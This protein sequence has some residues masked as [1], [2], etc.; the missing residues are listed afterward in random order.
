[1][2]SFSKAGAK[3]LLFFDMTKFFDKKITFWCIFFAYV[4]FL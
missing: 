4:I 3:V 2:L 1:M